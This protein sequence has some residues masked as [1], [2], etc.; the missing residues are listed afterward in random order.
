MYRFSWDSRAFDGMF[1]SAHALEIPFTFNTI[2]R[3]GVDLFIGPGDQPTALAET[4]HDA[5]IAF[6][7]DVYPS[8]AALVSW[9][10]YNPYSRVVM[11]LDDECGLLHDPRPEERKA[12]AGIVR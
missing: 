6:I 12:W 4:I 8:T 11:N 3:P 9:P 1:G 2:D 7:R 10:G 5:W